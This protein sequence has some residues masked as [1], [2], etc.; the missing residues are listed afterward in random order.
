MD[1]RSDLYSL[2]VTLWFLL[3]GRTPFRGNTLEEIHARQTGQSLPVGQL[4]A[5][6]VPAPVVSLLRT[7]LMVDPDRVPS[8][9]PERV[10]GSGW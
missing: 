6:R 2:G 10:R 8:F 4:L 1:T 5:R 7:T 3:S 9:G